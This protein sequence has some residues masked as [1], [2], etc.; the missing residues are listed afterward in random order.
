M[1]EVKKAY[2]DIM[3]AALSAYSREHIEEY[4]NRCE[5]DGVTEH[6]FPRLTSNIGILIANGRQSELKELFLQMMELC[7]SEVQKPPTANTGNNFSVRELISCV[8][9][10]RA[11]GTVDEARLDRWCEVL[12]TLDPY[13]AYTAIALKPEDRP[14]NWAIFATV[15]EQMKT[16]IGYTPDEEFIELQLSTQVIHLDENG[17]YRDP[18]EPMVYDA[19]SRGLFSLLIKHG[20]RGKYLEVIDSALRRAGL[21]TVDMQSATGEIPFGGRSNGFLH[22][23]GWIAAI[24][25]YEA[26]RY[27]KM[28]DELSAME[29]KSAALR[30][31]GV[32]ERWL[33]HEPIRHIKNYYPTSS[34][35]GCE[36]YAYFDKYMITCASIFYI[37]YTLCD[38]EL[39]ERIYPQGNVAGV[40]SEHFHK[41]FLR[42]GGY[43]LM[44]ELNADRHYDSS[45]IGKLQRDGASGEVCI[46][47]PSSSEAVFKTAEGACDNISL[48]PGTL[49]DG[50]PIYLSDGSFPIT[51]KECF[52]DA[53]SASATLEIKLGG[54][55]MEWTLRLSERGLTSELKGERK[56]LM[57]LP[58]LRNDGEEESE[59]AVERNALTVKH[60][61]SVCRYTS[62]GKITETDRRGSS[63]CG[64]LG[65]Y[66][67]I[68][69]FALRVGVEIFNEE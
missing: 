46:S 61:G 64:I 39:E 36:E 17:M 66:S 23:E 54:L 15:S 33:S 2:L 12:G 45:G 8:A 41:L 53:D 14:N 67:T 44:L 35:Y 51:V 49:V 56:L 29:F 3:E 16:A 65:A 5:R 6:G 27:A 7:I 62:S 63:R 32:A 48:C 24:C 21:M 55:E 52:A 9:E 38:P 19:V 34:G 69:Y 11:A 26:A 43:S 57:L 60:R 18:N 50:E 28:G 20:Y 25:E 68:A 13:R 47:V 42:A 10:L 1:N 59:I 40:T 4:F 31:R 37:A 22:N 58:Y 30:A